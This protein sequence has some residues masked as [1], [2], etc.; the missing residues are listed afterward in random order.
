MNTNLRLIWHQFRKETCEHRKILWSYGILV[1]VYAWL[2]G[3]ETLQRM[4]EDTGYTWL[5]QYELAP[6]FFTLVPGLFYVP[7]LAF[8]DSSN[9]PEAFWLTK[10]TGA[11]VVVAAKLLWISVWLIGM[12]LI[13]EGIVMI[14]LGG[15]AKL[16]YL[17]F[18]FVLLRAVFLF[19]TFAL[20]S[21]FPSLLQFIVVVIC[22]PFVGGLV[23]EPENSFSA[24]GALTVTLIWCASLA[25]VSVVGSCAQYRFRFGMKVGIPCALAAFYVLGLIN[26]ASV[27]LLAKPMS[28]ELRDRQGV[29]AMQVQLS[30]VTF[31]RGALG[32]DGK[33]RDRLRMGVTLSGVAPLTDLSLNRIS[34]V[35]KTSGQTLDIRAEGKKGARFRPDKDSGAR[36]FKSVVAQLKG[37]PLSPGT[38]VA[39]IEMEIPPDTDMGA[40]LRQPVSLSGRATFE[41]F[42]HREY[43]RLEPD[44]EYDFISSIAR[45]GSRVTMVWPGSSGERDRNIIFINQHLS[46]A[47]DPFNAEPRAKMSGHI[48]PFLYVLR[49]READSYL[50]NGSDHQHGQ[51]HCS[52]PTMLALHVSQNH[53]VLPAGAKA[54]EAI[55]YASHY[56]GTID[57]EFSL[58][59]ITLRTND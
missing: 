15:G 56:V 39:E 49:D 42:D 10:P 33:V 8:A 40:F 46:A 4:N 12:P 31:V 25:L 58:G 14:A 45:S 2:T 57:Q 22:I 20:A 28:A 44:L 9:E 27:D 54:D 1:A 18:D 24:S 21:L 43:G 34:L 41:T 19:T 48:G 32:A 59:D 6:F 37:E 7:I 29:E 36:V 26:T 55:I 47:S 13:G 38:I 3:S 50:E 5:M 16:F 52:A 51:W 30:A 53:V 17:A 11:L 23:G 35:L